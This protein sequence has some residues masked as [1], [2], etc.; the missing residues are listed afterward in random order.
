MSQTATAQS[1]QQGKLAFNA[2]PSHRLYRLRLARYKAL[3][4]RVAAFV[5]DSGADAP[6]ELLDVGPG[7]GRSMAFLEAE[8]V[9][10]ALRFTG[11]DNSKKRLETIHKPEQWSLRFGDV[12]EGLP[13]SDEEFDICLCEQVLEHLPEIDTTVD[14]M[15]RVLKPGGLMITGV[16]TF[17]PIAAHL[18]AA[19]VLFLDKAFG[20]KREHLQTFTARSFARL[21]SNSRPLRV[22]CYRGFRIV[23]GGMLSSLE[24][25]QWWYRINRRLGAALPSLCTE[26][27]VV[28]RK[29]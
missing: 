13:Y 15:V 28:L 12:T 14:E 10:D 6:L 2:V 19:G 17:P 9:A 29:T 25:Q 5:R 11:I 24:D 21:L 18:R 20:M 3:A 26:V 23:S 22:E 8:G 16:P 27:Q 7:S 1:A 4:E